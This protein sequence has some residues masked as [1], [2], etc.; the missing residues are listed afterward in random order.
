M[1]TYCRDV[2]DARYPAGMKSRIRGNLDG[3]LSAVRRDPKDPKHSSHF[4]LI[5]RQDIKLPFIPVRFVNFWAPNKLYE[6]VQNLRRQ[7]ERKCVER[8]RPPCAVMFRPAKALGLERSVCEGDVR[9][10]MLLEDVDE[11]SGFKLDEAEVSTEAETPPSVPTTI[12]STMS[13]L[14]KK[15][16]IPIARTTLELVTEKTAFTK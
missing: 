15:K 4:L 2:E 1:F 7:C 13:H 5:T 11:D 10:R 8:A 12:Y 3:C 9:L 16:C 14:I 6:F